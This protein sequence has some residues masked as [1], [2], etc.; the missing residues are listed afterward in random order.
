MPRTSSRRDVDYLRARGFAVVMCDMTE[1][2]F[3]EYVL[4]LEMARAKVPARSAHPSRTD[5][6]L[7][8]SRVPPALE[9][10]A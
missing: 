8:M 2:E 9:A 5:V 4:W 10:E 7:P 6:G 3:A 1:E